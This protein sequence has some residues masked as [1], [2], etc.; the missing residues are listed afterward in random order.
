MKK[1]ALRKNS[2]KRQGSIRRR[3]RNHN[4]R[5]PQTTLAAATSSPNL[6]SLRESQPDF[7]E[8]T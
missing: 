1:N 8:A 3:K 2:A 5:S 6:K 7:G 4:Q